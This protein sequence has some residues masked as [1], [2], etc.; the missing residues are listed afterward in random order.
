MIRFFS[1]LDKIMAEIGLENIIKLSDRSFWV[2]LNSNSGLVEGKIHFPLKVSEKLVIFEPGF[3]G[4]GSTQF[5]ELWL[6]QVLKQGF[7]V[8][9]IRHNGTII[10]GKFS[11]NYLNCPQRQKQALKSGLKLLGPKK[12]IS[13][14]DWLI[15]P[16]IAVEAV[17]SHFKEI[18]LVG[19]SFGP[20]ALVS[21]LIDLA[22]ENSPFI[23]RV[24]RVVSLAGAIGRARGKKDGKLEIW[25]KHLDTDWA[26][27]RV[28]IGPAK[29][30]TD[31][32]AKAHNKIH[33]FIHLFPSH[34]EF[35]GVTPLGDKAGT[36]DDL[37]QSIETVEFIASLGRGYLI[38][39]KIEFSDDKSGR[40]AHDMENLKADTLVK[41]LDNNWLPKQQISVL[42]DFTLE[43]KLGT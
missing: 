3:P 1:M 4:G 36:I 35:I 14:S 5:E 10:N 32:F 16:K 8:F 34:I 28:K 30:N 13:I 43:M 25:H 31:I 11:G 33:D 39:D 37:V 21:S 2:T 24:V 22:V 29:K 26:R 12:S 41:Y 20:L 42:K 7:T 19:H 6:N 15:E 18:Y 27:D 17:G 40:M 23:R 9:L 38:L